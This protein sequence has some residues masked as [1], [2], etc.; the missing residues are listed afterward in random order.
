MEP[1][2]SLQFLQEHF[3]NPYPETHQSIP[4]YLSTH[5]CLGLRSDLFP[6]GLLIDILYAFISSHIPATCPVY[7]ILHAKWVHFRH[8]M[9]RPQVDVGEEGLKIWK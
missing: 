5:L 8:S 3:I 2:C 4:S 9:A 7:H 6:S 1:E